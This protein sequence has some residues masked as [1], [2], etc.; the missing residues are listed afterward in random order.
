MSCYYEDKYLNE[1]NDSY[2]SVSDRKKIQKELE[3]LNKGDKNYFKLKRQPYEFSGKTVTVGVFGS[4][5][6]GSS[7]R[8]AVTGTR[9]KHKVGSRYEDLYFSVRLATGEAGKNSP[10][11]FFESPE[12]YE[13]HLFVEIDDNAKREWY[14]KNRVARQNLIAEEESRE[15]KQRTFIVR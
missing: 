13:Q 1:D 10:T 14:M 2:I 5:D 12:Q 6:V 11:L 7:I 15:K 3:E 8:D 4:G 9:Y